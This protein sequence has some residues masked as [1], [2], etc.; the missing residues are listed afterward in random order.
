[1]RPLKF[2]SRFVRTAPE[3]EQNASA[4]LRSKLK[5]P[6]YRATAACVRACVNHSAPF[7]LIARQL[8]AQLKH[9]VATTSDRA[10]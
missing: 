9:T 8:P 6:Y 4:C 5:E 3:T 2:E 1:M 7:F 10:I